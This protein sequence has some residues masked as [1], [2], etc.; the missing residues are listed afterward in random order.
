M[1]AIIEK[2]MSAMAQLINAIPV[3]SWLNNVTSVQLDPL[4][5][6]ALEAVSIQYGIGIMVSAYVTRFIIRRI[7]IVG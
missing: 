1:Q 2:L 7:P 5:T 3:P 4:I 6:W